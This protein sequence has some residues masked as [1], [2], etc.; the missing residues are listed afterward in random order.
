MLAKC[1]TLNDILYKNKHYK[2]D[3]I[4]FVEEKDVKKLVKQRAV[5]WLEA[6]KA[7]KE[8]IVFPITP[9]IEVIEEVKIKP[10]KKRKYTYKSRKKK[11]KKEKQYA[12]TK[13][14]S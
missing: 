2:I 5:R 7:K 9:V 3:K 8:S 13:A 10:K 1:I 6:P 4:I 14:K 11:K 12:Y